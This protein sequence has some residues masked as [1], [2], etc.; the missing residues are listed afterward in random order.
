MVIDWTVHLVDLVVIGGGIVGGLSMGIKL[1]DAIR[2]LS[3]EV[4]GLT[5][6]S[7]DH[8]FRL[9]TLEQQ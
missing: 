8:E 2:D 9:R 6:T 5:Q 7:Q 1:R 3:H 4:K